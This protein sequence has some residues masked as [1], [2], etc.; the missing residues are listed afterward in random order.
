VGIQ[1]IREV[2]VDAGKK[3]LPKKAAFLVEGKVDFV[4]VS[5]DEGTDEWTVELPLAAARQLV[6]K[7]ADLKQL[8][9]GQK[10]LANAAALV[11]ELKKDREALVALRES[12]SGTE[13]DLKNA[14]RRVKLLEKALGLEPGGKVPKAKAS[15]SLLS[16]LPPPTLAPATPVKAAPAPKSRQGAKGKAVKA[17]GA[18]GDTGH[19]AAHTSATPPAPFPDVSLPGNALPL[20][21]PPV[22]VTGSDA[23][24]ADAEK[25]LKG[26]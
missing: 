7:A 14:T 26:G 25:A 10:V 2:Q 18:K 15:D 11:P 22:L 20:E 19:G 8:K 16:D 12:S 13:V 6:R 4:A 23:V 24:V 21:T 17:N 5:H 9:A 3:D 1:R